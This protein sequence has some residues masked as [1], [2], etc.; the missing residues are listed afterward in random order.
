MAEVKFKPNPKA[1]DEIAATPEMSEVLASY[2][3]KIA[4]RA[5]ATLDDEPGYLVSSEEGRTQTSGPW[6]DRVY[7][8]TT[9]AQNSTARHN[10]LLRSM[11]MG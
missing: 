4:D 6:V 11:G 5:N 3:R 9:H 10:T 7:A 8:A 1:A 2:A